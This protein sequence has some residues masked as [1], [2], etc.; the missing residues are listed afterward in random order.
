MIPNKKS[1]LIPEHVGYRKLKGFQ[2]AQLVYDIT[3]RFCEQ[4][5]ER[6]SRT[7]DQMVQAARSGVQNIAEGSQVSATSKKMELKLTQ[8]ARASLEEL[9]L[10]YEDFLRHKELVELDPN[11]PILVRFKELRCKSLEDV[12]RWV[13]EEREMGKKSGRTRTG[14]DGHR[15]TDEH[16]RGQS[17]RRV[18]SSA[19]LAANAA[20]S[21][22]NLACYLLDRQVQ[23]LAKDFEE[24]GGFTERL[25]RTRSQSRRR[26]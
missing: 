23:R 25:Y 3:I 6:G 14:T 20:L 16:G 17:S 22:L 12:H 11:D 4:Y 5:I 26:P 1:E 10:N 18:L 9:K 19:C 15:H 21:L 8:V 7:K 13:V 24:Q 2:L